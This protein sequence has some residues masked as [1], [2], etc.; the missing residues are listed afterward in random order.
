[1]KVCLEGA[2]KCM[3]RVGNSI[4]SELILILVMIMDLCLQISK[5]SLFELLRGSVRSPIFEL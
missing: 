5:M 3:E 2:G 1:M 4:H